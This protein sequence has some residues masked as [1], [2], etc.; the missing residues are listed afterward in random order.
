M[1]SAYDA[2]NT[3]ESLAGQ[4]MKMNTAQRAMVDGLDSKTAPS[5]L[6][7][8]QEME[9]ELQAQNDITGAVIKRATSESNLTVVQ[10]ESIISA[11]QGNAVDLESVSITKVLAKEKLDDLVQTKGLTKAQEQEILASLGVTAANGTQKVSFDVLK[12]SIIATTKAMLIQIATNPATWIVA[13]VAAI[14]LAVTA[15]DKL[16]KTTDELSED[17]QTTQ[18]SVDSLNSK[19]QENKNLIE[20]IKNDNTISDVVKDEDI[21]KLEA[22]NAQLIIKRDA[23]Q[24]IAKAAGDAVNASI[25]GDLNKGSVMEGLFGDN[26]G[27]GLSKLPSVVGQPKVSLFTDTETDQQKVAKLIK[28]YRDLEAQQ[29]A[30]DAQKKS[31]AI[32]D[33]EYIK[34]HDELSSKMDKT[35][36]SAGELVKGLND[37]AETAVKGSDGYDEIQESVAGTSKAYTDCF[38]SATSAANGVAASGEAA[39][40]AAG[41]VKTLAEII[42][43]DALATS[44]TIDAIDSLNSAMNAQTTGVGI[45]KA[46]YDEL[47]AV[48]DD[49]ASALEYANGTMQLNSERV[50]EITD[51]KIAESEATLNVAM[52][53]DQLK[54]NQNASEIA[55]LSNQLTQNTSLTNEQRTAIEAQ[56]DALDE[57]NGTLRENCDGYALLYSSLQ[58]ATGAYKDWQNAQSATETGSM[59]DD[60]ISAAQ[61]IQDGL[62]SGKVGTSKFKASVEFLIPDDIP[63]EDISKYM[64]KVNRYITDDI[65]GKSDS[66]GINNFLDDAIAKGLMSEDKDGQIKVAAGK[67]MQD[68]CDAMEI[69]PEMAQSIFGELQEYDFEFDWGDENPFGDLITNQMMKIDELQE[70]MDGLKPGTD[71]WNEVN[72]EISEA[73]NQLDQMQASAGQ[74]NG[75]SAIW[76]AIKQYT[77]A[78]A[79]LDRSMSQVGTMG[80]YDTSG[81]EKIAEDTKQAADNLNNMGRVQVNVDIADAQA[82]VDELQSKFNNKDFT[83]AADLTDAQNQLSALEQQK[84][85]LGEPTNLEIQCYMENAEE[86]GADIDAITQKLQDVGVLKVDSA[87]AQNGIT[88]VNGQ[89]DDLATKTSIPYTLTVGTGMS[90]M[91]LNEL[92]GVYDQITDKSVTVNVTTN[93]TENGSPAAGTAPKTGGSPVYTKKSGKG[94]ASGTANAGGNW[95]LSR[96]ERSLVGELGREVVV[97]PTTG[98]WYTV[99]DN[100]AEFANLPQGAI[101]F[102]HEQSEAL[103]ERGFVS[104]RGTT[105]L[106]AGTARVTGGGYR[107]G[108]NPITTGG[109]SSGSGSKATETV[110]KVEQAADNVVKAATE[111][112]QETNKAAESAAKATDSTK[113]QEDAQQKIIDALNDQKE[114]IE[115]QKKA[116]ED[117][118]SNLEIVAK[119][120]KAQIQQYI[121]I[122]EEF[123][124]INEDAIDAMQDDMQTLHDAIIA[125]LDAEI[126]RENEKSDL[127]DK[128]KQ[129]LEDQYTQIKKNADAAVDRNSTA[130]TAVGNVIDVQ[131]GKLQEQQEAI[132]AAH[133]AAIAPIQSEID[134]LQAQNDQT[135]QAIDLEEK[136]AALEKARTN[137]SIRVYRKGQGFVYETDKEAIKKAEQDLA[138]SENDA[139]VN[140][141]QAQIDRMEKAFEEETAAIQEKIDAYNKYK[142]KLE[143]FADEFENAQNDKIAQ[144]ILGDDWKDKII[145]MDDATLDAFRIKYLAAQQE[146]ADI[147]AKMDENAKQVEELE[148]QQKEIDDKIAKIEEQKK[149]Y[150]EYVQSF[151]DKKND[152]IVDK[153]LGDGWE[154]KLFT[155]A[156]G[157]LDD[158]KG[159][160]QGLLDG[161]DASN[162]TI[163]K[164]EKS[165]NELNRELDQWDEALNA[166][167]KA[168]NEAVTQTALGAN[169]QWLVSFVNG[170]ITVVDKFK[171]AYFAVSDQIA[172]K[173]SEIA[174]LAAQINSLKL[175]T[176]PTLPAVP[177]VPVITTDDTVPNGYGDKLTDEV[178]THA[179]GALDIKHP[180]L[181]VT[182]EAGDEIKIRPMQGRYSVLEKGSSVIPANPSKNLWAFGNNPTEFINQHMTGI[183]LPKNRAVQAPQN[184]PI[185]IDVGG[186]EMNGVNDVESFGKVLKN[187]AGPIIAQVFAKRD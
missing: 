185:H 138:K 180:E 38:G 23:L 160:Y 11:L 84:A 171:V 53:Q 49:Y 79:E 141:L 5:R 46:A 183:T 156:G 175:P 83:V 154:E 107:P 66:T 100:G 179:D 182:D 181:A 151:E 16:H 10:K 62:D 1:D 42:Q 145:A 95:G 63:E 155:D 60:V 120:A 186:I 184:Q 174:A 170:N 35:K 140:A 115:A 142:E 37:I 162:E 86:T 128:Q 47:I 132:E 99:G 59:Y 129:Q 45:T 65:D 18:N 26:Y 31:G 75:G 166:Y 111:A 40:T 153:Y 67:V 58:Q 27:Y 92:K 144:D 168:K 119:T 106:A 169:W 139:R 22:E 133:K 3:I 15:Y 125:K 36:T 109:G 55:N 165:I 7:Q 137:R 72:Q 147:Q 116:Y 98:R 126:D 178:K 9:K 146:Q 112:A 20:N 157:A 103:L 164:Y 21:A 61:Q 130:H 81:V 134:A 82:K 68:F 71:G 123:K 50:Q 12:T 97:N 32:T 101:V 14:G 118:K 85:K 124:K 17:Y 127:L 13:A 78:K 2:G 77:E 89:V 108:K 163:A 131:I 87:E 28:T 41:E 94:K 24:E 121:D 173:T 161:I 74:V 148:K 91:V 114:I 76:D 159:A 149:K 39:A 150:D 19:L 152:E 30:L 34:R 6:P 105:A 122:D 48:D 177:A 43:E 70:K 80:N 172:A 135:Q 44:A 187:K 158:F 113:E 110:K 54:Y 25:K 90:M 56:I 57:E 69:T 64:Q 143:A 8:I 88:T 33:E 167:D 102:N 96:A 4:Y 136:R 104:G 51:K 29:K 117:Q 176:V 52:S 73:K 93:Y